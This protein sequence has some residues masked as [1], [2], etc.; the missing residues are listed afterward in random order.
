MIRLEVKLIK[1]ST[2][3]TEFNLRLLMRVESLTATAICDK[4]MEKFHDGSGINLCHP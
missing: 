2:V 1:S 4:Y 3:V